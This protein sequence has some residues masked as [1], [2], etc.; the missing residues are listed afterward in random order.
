MFGTDASALRAGSPRKIEPARPWGTGQ[1]FV[2]MTPMSAFAVSMYPWGRDPMSIVAYEEDSDVRVAR[3]STLMRPCAP[4]SLR[5]V[6]VKVG[7]KL[8]AAACPYVTDGLRTF[9]ARAEQLHAP[10][11]MTLAHGE[12]GSTLYAVR[13]D[14]HYWML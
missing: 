10:I 1:Q 5:G 12:V 13:L 2:E 9:L 7:E 3:G 6:G 8:V 4:A 14:R 11:A